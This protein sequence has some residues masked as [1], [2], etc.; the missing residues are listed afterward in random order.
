VGLTS[1]VVLSSAGQIQLMNT[2]GSSQVLSLYTT[3]AGSYYALSST[4]QNGIEVGVGQPVQ[5]RFFANVLSPGQY[6]ARSVLFTGGQYTWV[7]GFDPLVATPVTDDMTDTNISE[8]ET[9]TGWMPAMPLSLQQREGQTRINAQLGQFD[10]ETGQTRLYNAMQLA[11][12]FSTSTDVTP[13]QATVVD[14]LWTSG[15]NTIT[16]KVG[17][18]DASGI[19]RVLVLYDQPNANNTS[20][21]TGLW[22]G[23]DLR[24]DPASQKWVGGFPGR[25]DT[26]FW[27]QLVDG[28][29]N[30]QPVNNKGMYF[31]PGVARNRLVAYLPAISRP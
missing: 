17:A 10:A 22:R 7:D 13:P 21:Q 23:A 30:A 31:V 9:Q 19:A 3:S 14:G 1:T 2:L 20:T 29:G 26:R 15:A 25:S 6:R 5:P 24:Y 4:R 16:V 12:Y 27:V 8:M 28:A 11:L 18:T